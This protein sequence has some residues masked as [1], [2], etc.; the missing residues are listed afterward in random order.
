MVHMYPCA[1]RQRGSIAQVSSFEYIPHESVEARHAVS[2]PKG[3]GRLVQ[4]VPASRT[5]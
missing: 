1:S 3:M 5:I 4:V 2:P